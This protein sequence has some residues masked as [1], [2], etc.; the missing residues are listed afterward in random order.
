M[1]NYTVTDYSPFNNNFTV[2]LDKKDTILTALKLN[3]K[4]NFN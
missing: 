1:S 3:S 4:D 2:W